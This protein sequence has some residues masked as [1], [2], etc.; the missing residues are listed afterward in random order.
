MKTVMSIADVAHTWAHQTQTYA[1]NSNYSFYFDGQTIYSYGSHFPIATIH[2]ELNIVLY[3]RRSYSITTACH[4][5]VV[6][7]AID[8]DRYTILDAFYLTPDTLREH[9]INVNGYVDAI[10]ETIGKFNRATKYKESYRRRHDILVDQLTTYCKVFRIKSKILTAAKRI[11]AA[12]HMV[13]TPEYQQWLDTKAEHEEQARARAAERARVREQEFIHNVLP[14]W[15]AGEARNIWQYNVSGIYLRVNGGE[16]QTS[17]GAHITI[18]QARVLWPYI[19]QSHEN[20]TAR[21]IPAINVYGAGKIDCGNL[22]I[23]CHYILYSELEYIAGELGL[24]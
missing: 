13:I 3:T 12:G 2:P 24:I 15:R 20:Q 11:I 23:G 10:K 5:S 18:E 22:K 4:K 6:R 1:R 8:L 19:Q 16:I 17:R 7:R 9:L 14:L 21:D